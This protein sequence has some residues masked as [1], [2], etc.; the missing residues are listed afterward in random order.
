MQLRKMATVRLRDQTLIAKIAKNDADERVRYQAIMCLNDQAH[1]ADVVTNTNHQNDE[2]H[3]LAIK[4]LTDQ[5][6]LSELAENDENGK[7][8]NTAGERLKK[9]RETS[10]EKATKPEN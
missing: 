9:L 1:I 6:L 5:A 2:A 10:E 7:V 3:L 4:M 8:R